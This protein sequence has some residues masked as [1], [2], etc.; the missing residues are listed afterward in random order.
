MIFDS[1]LSPK[2][3][4]FGEAKR[5]RDLGFREARSPE[6]KKAHIAVAGVGS[7]TTSE[8]I[9]RRVIGELKSDAVSSEQIFRSR[10]FFET[11][12]LQSED[13]PE[14]DEVALFYQLLM[15]HGLYKRR[16]D[17]LR[18]YKSELS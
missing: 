9:R 7:D 13:I 11:N 5:K 3:K 10:N 14:G 18:K 15:H 6:N 2:P 16:F 17:L 1:V 4:D 12:S 8:L